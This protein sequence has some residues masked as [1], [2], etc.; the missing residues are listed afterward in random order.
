MASSLQ[1]GLSPDEQYIPSIKYSS[2]DTS[3]REIRLILLGDNIELHSH[4]L[5]AVPP[6]RAISYHWG[7]DAPTCHVMI[8]GESIKIRES[9]REM[10]E[11]LKEIYECEVYFGV[12]ILCLYLD[13]SRSKSC[14]NLRFAPL[15]WRVLVFVFRVPSLRAFRPPFTWRCLNPESSSPNQG[16]SKLIS[17]EE[18]KNGWIDSAVIP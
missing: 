14:R 12:D 17:S 7:P 8:Q 15:F 9:A 11:V 5:D 13:R 6:Y 10:L 16:H 2:I 3:K 1:F 4:S 18:G